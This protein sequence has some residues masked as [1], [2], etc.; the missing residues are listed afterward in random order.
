MRHEAKR[1]T[2]ETLNARIAEL[3]GKIAAAKSR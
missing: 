3:N 2:N 1:G